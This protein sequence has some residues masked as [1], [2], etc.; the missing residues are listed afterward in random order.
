MPRIRA[1]TVVVA[2][3]ALAGGLAAPSAADEPGAGAPF[4]YAELAALSGLAAPAE[5]SFTL[6]RAVE[7][8]LRPGLDWPVAG[9]FARGDV[10]TAFGATLEPD[11]W[12]SVRL[13]G[14]GR[15]WL[16]LADAGDQSL[17]VSGL[18]RAVAPAIL[19]APPNGV[20]VRM[21]AW[22]NGAEAGWLSQGDRTLAV[23]GRSLDGEWIAV[24]FYGE[25]QWAPAA[26]FELLANDVSAA[27]LPIFIPRE[28]TLAPV[29]PGADLQPAVL[30]RAADW[31]WTADGQIVGVGERAIWRYDPQAGALETHPRPPGNATIAPDGEHVAVAECVDAWRECGKPHEEPFDIVI[32]P[33]DG[34]GWM[35]VR[36][37][38]HSLVGWKFGTP[39]RI[40]EWSP[41]GRALLVPGTSPHRDWPGF[42]VEYS[43]ITVDGGYHPLPRLG[44]GP[45]QYW[46]WLADGTL[47]LHEPFVD[48]SPLHVATREGDRLREID[49]PPA[50]ARRRFG[51]FRTESGHPWASLQ[52]AAQ[53]RDGNWFLLDLES[54][55]AT[56]LEIA[57]S[58]A[59]F[60]EPSTGRRFAFSTM[61]GGDHALLLFDGPTGA[62]AQLPLPDGVEEIGTSRHFAPSGERLLLDVRREGEWELY[63]VELGSGEWIEVDVRGREHVCGGAVRW[64]PD[65]ERFAIERRELLER[66]GSDWYRRD[67]LAA[68]DGDAVSVQILIYSRTGAFIEAFRTLEHWPH[69]GVRKVEWSPDGR[70][71]GFGERTVGPLECLTGE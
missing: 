31:A 41:D 17:P 24:R 7:V 33:T 6:E 71:L 2:A 19:A 21:R 12:L 4:P 47:L 61:V 27:D 25:V 34:G 18:P 28:T 26:E 39:Y 53:S 58:T 67:G 66:R 57:E 64:S 20:G 32:V 8:R 11:P 68:L 46:V 37:I 50:F 56:M 23:V 43:V 40:G 13:P 42:T 60:G 16:K 5:V 49:L 55:A 3:L 38:H 70:W 48:D 62:A 10:V 15:G 52:A 54:G 69:S 22:P 14:G 29:E 45:R 30:P 44:T 59:E 63:V 35:R 51:W 65:G 1:I 36:D 9:R